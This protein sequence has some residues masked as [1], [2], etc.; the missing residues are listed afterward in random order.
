MKDVRKTAAIT[1]GRLRIFALGCGMDEV[2]TP[3]PYR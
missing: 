1:R 2:M 3:N